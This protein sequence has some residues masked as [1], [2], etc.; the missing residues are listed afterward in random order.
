[1]V[2]SIKAN[3]VTQGVIRPAFTMIELIFVIVVLGILSAVAIPRLAASRD[4]AVLVKGKS[5]VSAIRSGISLQKSKRMMEGTTPF[6]PT[7]L[8]GITTYNADNQRLFNYAD[9][10]SS[11]ILEY[12]IYSKVNHDGS[13][14][15]TA[16]NA[17]AYYLN[18]TNVAFDYNTT[19]GSFDCDHSNQNCKD[20]AE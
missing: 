12:P 1:M 10:N 9:G 5:Q 20:L 14:A 7:S 3:N 6:I 13:W 16:A 15:K 4:D 18:N 11:N 8:D 19:S 2:I 17:Y